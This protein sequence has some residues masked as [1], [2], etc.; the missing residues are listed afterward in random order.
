[1]VFDAHDQVFMF[2][3]DTCTRSIYDN[4]KMAVETI[5]ISKEQLYN[6]CFQQICSH[7]LVE[8]VAYTLALSWEKGQVKN[9]VGLVR[10]CFFMLHL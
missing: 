10:E 4:M 1:M 9:Q 7:Y 8:L 5:F 2:F 3:K 6:H